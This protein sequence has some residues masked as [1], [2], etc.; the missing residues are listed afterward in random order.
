LDGINIRADVEAPDLRI[1]AYVHYD[2][3]IFLRYDLNEPAQEFRGTRSTGEDSVMCGSH[4][5]ILRGAQGWGPEVQKDWRNHVLDVLDLAIGGLSI[6]KPKDGSRAVFRVRGI[7]AIA[8]HV[9]SHSGKE[10]IPAPQW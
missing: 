4:A 7:L 6:Q 5:N 10:I 2:M 9:L 3:N 1:V 8:G